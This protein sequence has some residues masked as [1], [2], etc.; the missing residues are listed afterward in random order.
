MD[1]ED[2]KI[3]VTNELILLC[4]IVWL[5][6]FEVSFSNQNT[7]YLLGIDCKTVIITKEKIKA[8]NSSEKSQ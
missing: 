3:L 1:P 2:P 6:K 7:I 5:G 4:A 8:R